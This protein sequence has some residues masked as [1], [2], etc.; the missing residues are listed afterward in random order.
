MVI[1]TQLK[2]EL[3]GLLGTLGLWTI[4]MQDITQ[5]FQCIAA[6]LAVFVAIGTIRL[7][8]IKIRKELNKK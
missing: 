4:S 3:F 1:L 6:I 2:N 7:T 8:V 5:V